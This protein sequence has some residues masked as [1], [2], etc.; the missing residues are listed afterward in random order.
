M[1]VLTVLFERINKFNRSKD[2]LKTNSN[3]IKFPMTHK[4]HVQ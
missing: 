1:Y 2:P 3:L 4:K